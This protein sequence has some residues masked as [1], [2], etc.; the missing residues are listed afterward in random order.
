MLTVGKGGRNY[1]LYVEDD[2]EDVELLKYTLDELKIQIPIIHVRNGVEALNSLNDW[3]AA[4]QL[5]SIIL[6][7]INMA[8]MDGKE[9]LL[10]LRADPE[11]ARIPILV[12]TVSRDKTDRTYFQR[13][14]VPYVVKPGDVHRF[15]KDLREALEKLLPYQF[16]QDNQKIA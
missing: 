8:K 1:A 15:R 12:L 6:I 14:D 3:R 16:Q 2:P 11:I 4:G 5:P 9:T 10:C 13:Y 7:D